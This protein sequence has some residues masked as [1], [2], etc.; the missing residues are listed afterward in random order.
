MLQESL[1]FLHGQ[2]ENIPYTGH[3][4]KKTVILG[5]P[6]ARDVSECSGYYWKL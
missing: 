3:F 1:M 2:Q 5:I 4:N 6:Q